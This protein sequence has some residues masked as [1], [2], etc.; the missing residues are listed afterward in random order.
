MLWNSTGCSHLIKLWPYSGSAL[1]PRPQL[2]MLKPL[3][4]GFFYELLCTGTLFFSNTQCFRSR[5][6]NIYDEQPIAW[7]QIFTRENRRIL[8]L[9]L[10]CSP[11]SQMCLSCGRVAYILFSESIGWF[12]AYLSNYYCSINSKFKVISVSS[13]LVS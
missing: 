1:N 8:T 3:V 13:F 9:G 5:F 4:Q 11:S 7:D 12:K 6:H 2:M 10:L